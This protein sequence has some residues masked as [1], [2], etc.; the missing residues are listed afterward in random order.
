ML[1]TLVTRIGTPETLIVDNVAIAVELWILDSYGGFGTLE[2]PGTPVGKIG[3]PGTTVVDCVMVVA[4]FWVLRKLKVE[5]LKTGV[6]KFPEG[7]SKGTFPASVV[8]LIAS[9]VR[10]LP[11]DNAS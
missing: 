2:I 6:F 7:R 8:D 10:M 9:D 11:E 4:E 5:L 3:G 1:E